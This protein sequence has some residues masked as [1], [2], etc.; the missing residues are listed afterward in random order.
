MSV[1]QLRFVIFL[2]DYTL[3]NTSRPHGPLF[4]RW[5]PD[6]ENNAIVLKT[7]DANASLRVWF[8]RC[9]FLKDGWITFDYM[10]HEV[11]LEVMHK[12]GVLDAGPLFGI[13]KIQGIS[14][15]EMSALK[16][17]RKGDPHYVMLGKR[18]T[19]DLLYSPVAKLLNTL[20]VNYGQYWI[21]E[22]KTWDSRLESIGHYCMSWKLEWSLD[23]GQTWTP[24]IPDQPTL[25]F[26]SVIPTAKS[27]QEYLTEKDWPDVSRV[28]GE[29]YEPSHGAF[30]L[31]RAHE[32]LDQGSLKHALIEGISAL[33]LVMWE[34]LRLRLKASDSLLESLQAFWTLPLHTQVIAVAVTLD[35][36]SLRDLELTIK[37]ISMRHKV[38]HE[39]ADVTET[40]KPEIIALL[41][42]SASF[43]SGPKFRFPSARGGNAILPPEA[44]E[45]MSKS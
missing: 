26:I 17:D 45:R 15:E 41:R 34:F 10:R 44:W 3:P 5:L 42:T 38:A 36:V 32:L 9:D 35:T 19:K 11:D 12:Q 7:G 22:L 20:R 6:G 23:D 24:F 14:E 29:D 21:Q 30:A 18:I 39:G 16:D 33:E 28:L 31:A 37:A 4:H 40:E 1:L 2:E 25:H 27:F 43:L 8:R 13:L